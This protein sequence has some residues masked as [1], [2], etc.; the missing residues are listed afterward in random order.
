M[1]DRVGRAVLIAV[2]V[3]VVVGL[4]GDVL[5]GDRVL[6]T[7]NTYRWLPWA[8]YASADLAGEKTYRTDAARTYLPRRVQAGRSYASG[9]LPLWN[10]YILGGTPFFADP[11]TRVV[12]PLALALLPLDG[13]RSMGYDVALHFLLAMLGMLLFLGAIGS[14]STGRMLG[15]LAYGLS[16][17]F[18]LRMGHPTFVATA[19]WLPWIFFAYERSRRAKR[20]GVLLLALFLG[21]GY[22]AGMPQIFMFAVAALAVYTAFDVVESLIRQ[23]TGAAAARIKVLCLGLAIALLVVGV[24]LVPFIEFTRNSRGLGF[25]FEM[26]SS[27]HLWSPVFL[28]RT[29][30][31][32]LF[33]NP[34]E[35]TSWIGL[36]K[37]EVHP[38]NSGF[39]VYCGIGGLSLALASLVFL[40]RSR[41]VRALTGL[42]LLS[43]GAGTSAAV[44]RIIHGVF[45]PAAYSQIDRVSVVACFALAALAGRGISLASASEDPALR[46]RY[47]LVPVAVAG[48][49]ACGLAL[50]SVYGTGILSGLSERVGPLS[51]EVWFRRSGFRLIEWVHQGV[52]GWFRYEMRQIALGF[53]FAGLSAL[54][55]WMHVN[56]RGH[57]RLSGF[58][59]W[60]LGLV[61]VMDLGLAARKYYVTQPAGCLFETE[62]IEVLS[63]YLGGGDRWRIGNLGP[64]DR[65][66]PANTAQIY[67]IPSFGGLNAMYP[68]GYV[69]R[70]GFAAALRRS[71][72]PMPAI[73]GPVGNLM[74]T[75]FLVADRAYPE[76]LESPVMRA[77]MEDGDLAPH[78]AVVEVGGDRRLSLTLGVGE[79]CSLSVMIPACRSLGF[80]LGR[81]A[82]RTGVDAG[83][84]QVVVT[85]RE[86]GGRRSIREVVEPAMGE[87]RWEDFDIDVS[88]LAETGAWIY[89]HLPAGSNDP[90]SE[91][92]LSRFEFVKRDCEVKEVQGGY[93]ILA[94][95]SGGTL[96]LWLEASGEFPV[97]IGGA[98]GDGEYCTRWVGFDRRGGS[99]YLLLGEEDRDAVTTVLADEELNLLKARLIDTGAHPVMGLAPVYDG[100]MF[101]CENTSALPRGICVSREVLA[102]SGGTL[103]GAGMLKIGNAAGRLDSHICG[104]VSISSSENETLDAEVDAGEDC[105]LL[106][107][108]TWY[109]GWRASVDGV[110]TDVLR[111]DMGIRA[112]LV[113]RGR[114]RVTMEF[115]PGS[116]KLGLIL[117]IAGI[118][119]GVIYGAKAKRP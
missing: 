74:A 109:P 70:V 88:D 99:A 62:G 54:W 95:P 75:R 8:E 43:V 80:S 113:D 103:E 81:V 50:F 67:G 86:E 7:S 46:R 12:Y 71:G 104:R 13:A 4:F 110:E 58:A 63:D 83:A 34:V 101:I 100:D 72:H 40:G 64:P 69:E 68:S 47:T 29:L 22:L 59:A 16:S 94:G 3:A 26:M 78:V 87:R 20:S 25:S 79:V 82:G 31:H 52:D 116:F 14:T 41:H 117:S 112:L 11:Q 90:G 53:V 28:L 5:V 44:L 66:M 51:E 49:M 93:E 39:M 36:L 108:D 27:E 85:L 84:E 9:S 42:L 98:G 37:G 35:G 92:A 114:H 97:R 30:V 18:F 2:L 17:F 91:I 107:Q 89:F 102:G 106:F 32:D 115:D 24:H 15:A 23:D 76:L 119:V 56:L 60:L 19:A 45:P 33:G 6:I 105:L 55:I 65:V 1:T 96:A 48:I 61:L 21:L 118:V 57:R 111:T 10:P 77:I 73:I 38:Y